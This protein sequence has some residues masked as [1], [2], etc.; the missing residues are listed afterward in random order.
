MAD[1]GGG[2]GGGVPPPTTF[3]SIDQAIERVGTGRFQRKLL[4]AAG[5]C[6]AADSMEVLLLSFL[7]VVV[8]SEWGLTSEQTSSITAAVFLGAMTGT[9]ILGPLGDKF[10][11]KP[12]FVL[13]AAIIA[14][15][16]L[17]TAV[18]NSLAVLI[19]IRFMVGVGVGGLVVPFD[20]VAEFVPTNMRG[21][22]LLYLGYY[23]AL[24]TLLV[25]IL[26]FITL[27]DNENGD[28]P[29]G[30]WRWFTVL[31]AIPCIASTILGIIWVPESPHWLVYQGR[32]DKALEV[33]KIAAKENGLNPD[34]VFPMGTM[35]KPDDQP[36]VHSVMALLEPEWRNLT[37]KL[38][39]TWFGFAF[40]YYGTVILVT[41]VFA[42]NGSIEGS[43]GMAQGSYDFDY[44]AIL[45]AGSAEMVGQTFVILTV[46]T[47]GRVH[48]QALSYLLGG[49]SVL[50]LALLEASGSK[51]GAM[52]FVAFLA[53]MFMMGSSS[54]TWVATAE[55]LPTKI[56]NTGHAAANAM[57]R[58]GGAISPFVVSTSMSMTTIGIIMGVVSFF[59][60]ALSW[61]LP[62]TQGKALGTA[63]TDSFNGG[64]IQNG[65]ASIEPPT[66]ELT[67]KTK[68]I[69]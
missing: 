50:G 32:N 20:T 56:R 35:V 34:E 67:D 18:A 39:G 51:R 13:S 48:T 19:I 8:Q 4:L 64:S 33:L 30:Q 41:L 65:T 3:L 29:S 22:H 16:G 66:V 55:I 54:T 44:A 49:F 43:E 47:W 9:L 17:L 68:E 2:G 5:L 40:L 25:P 21:Y 14:I 37:L 24:G 31:C 7:A 60:C 15:F 36:E 69:I 42:E 62:E 26:A 27:G 12:V 52:M 1:D 63:H 11:R 38:W 23:W 58:L 10:G 61:S 6:F 57:A 53:R 46:E 28:E 59:T 45:L